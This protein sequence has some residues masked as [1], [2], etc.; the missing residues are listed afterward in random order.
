MH[1]APNQR[2]GRGYTGRNRRHEQS[3]ENDDAA[4]DEC[5]G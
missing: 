4:A 5:Q 3:K 1:L 2:N